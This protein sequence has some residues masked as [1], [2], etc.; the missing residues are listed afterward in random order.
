MRTITVTTK[1]DIE[2]AKKEKYDEIIISGKLADQFK[3][4]KKIAFAGKLTLLT[5]TAI[6]GTT[7]AIAPVTGGTSVALGATSLVAVSA[8]TGFEIAAIIAASSIGI[9]LLV[10]I[11]SGYEEIGYKEG[12]LTLRKKQ[13]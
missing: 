7:I 2:K 5:L 10:A 6:A 11:F 9:S 3:K 4:A 8:V 13:K 1:K 12:E